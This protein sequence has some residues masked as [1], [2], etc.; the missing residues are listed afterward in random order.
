MQIQDIV[1]K[2]GLRILSGENNLTKDV[3]CGYISDILSDVMAKSAKGAIWVTNQT[4]ENIIAIVFFKNLAGVIL[5]DNL[6]PEESALQ[7]A[8]EKSIPIFVSEYSAFD[9]AGKLYEL[10]IRGK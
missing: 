1:T 2:L 8:K 7:K 4:H 10:G 3:T 9:I 5:P 6:Q